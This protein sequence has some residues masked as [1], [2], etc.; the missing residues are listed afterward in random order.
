MKLVVLVAEIGE[1]STSMVGSCLNVSYI[2][3]CYDVV[4]VSVCFLLIY[5][6]MESAL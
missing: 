6:N 1:L 2:D 5:R 4:S 3:T